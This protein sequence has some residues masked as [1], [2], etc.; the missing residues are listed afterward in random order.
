MFL[1]IFYILNKYDAVDEFL[2]HWIIVCILNSIFIKLIIFKQY[3]KEHLKEN[4]LII[5]KGRRY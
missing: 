3:L 2:A 4:E 5:S 1:I